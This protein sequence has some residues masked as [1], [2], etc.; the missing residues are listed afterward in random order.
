MI[1]NPSYPTGI[2]S[3]LLTK[4]VCTFLFQTNICTKWRSH[5]CLS[6]KPKFLKYRTGKRNASRA[7]SLHQ[8][9]HQEANSVGRAE[10]GGGQLGH[11]LRHGKSVRFT[12]LVQ[13]SQGVELHHDTE[14]PDHRS[15]ILSL[16][17]TLDKELMSLH[18]RSLCN[19]NRIQWT[20]YTT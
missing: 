9:T 6:S 14:T 12:N 5:T 19:L 1:T 8:K 2:F 13:H 20:I 17:Y 4:Q 15:Y 18:L 16:D 10:T 11:H 3:T 7:L